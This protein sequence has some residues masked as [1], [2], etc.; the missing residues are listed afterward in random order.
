MKNKT[1]YITN[2]KVSASGMSRTF[3]AYILED[4]NLYLY[5]SN[6]L[7]QGKNIGVSAYKNKLKIYGGGMDMFYH[8]ISNIEGF[9][10]YR[11]L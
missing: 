5:N 9:E 4:N 7:E 1:L 10:N 3:D 6:L 2:I 11:I 8:I